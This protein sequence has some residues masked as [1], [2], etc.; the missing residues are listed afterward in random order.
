MKKRLLLLT[1]FA[2]LCFSLL[3]SQQYDYRKEESS[4]N[5]V[6]MA[7]RFK[8]DF[9]KTDE[10]KRIADNVL[11]YQLTT[12]GWPK[13]IFM[14]KELTATEEDELIQAK[15]NVDEGTIDN[16]AT[17]SEIQYLAK[18]YREHKEERYKQAVL[19]GIDYLLEAQYDN[20]GWPQCYPR[21][22][23]YVTQI[24]YNDNS[25]V[26]V[27]EF[28][29]DIYENRELYPFVTGE[30]LDRL[31]KAFDK[32][33]DCILKTQVVQNGKLT[34]WCAQ[35]DH[36]TLKPAQ[37]RAYELVSLSGQESDNIILLLMSLKNPSKEV[38]NAVVGAVDW[39]K[40]VQIDGVKIEYFT[41]EEGKKDRRLVKCIGDE[42]CPPTW[43]RF[44]DID[45]NEPFVCDRDGIKRYSLSEI[46]YER[47][48]GYKWY[49][50]DGM[51]VFKRYEEWKKEIK[52]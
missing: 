34:V 29:R 46:G 33:I 3:F 7:S 51:E 22:R 47:R 4:K 19:D 42:D 48:M 25:N 16:G 21:T 45:T 2:A 20:G 28:V 8:D 18:V 27:L 32:G 6:R 1:G 44:Y 11:L 26:N 12:G 37:A 50:N 17:T 30:R 15:T 24:Q 38:I 40:E 23:G 14:P 5:W 41:D 10:A 49:N 36:K 31:K 13:N 43:A 39:F 9:Y 35:Y 52:G